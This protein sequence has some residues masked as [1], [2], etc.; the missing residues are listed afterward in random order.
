MLPPEIACDIVHAAVANAELRELCNVLEKQVSVLIALY[1]GY[2]ELLM[3]RVLMARFATRPPRDVDQAFEEAISAAWETNLPAA[4]AGKL[5]LE[6]CVD[7][8]FPLLCIEAMRIMKRDY[9]KAHGT[10]TLRY[11]VCNN[12]TEFVRHLLCCW[13]CDYN[14][15]S[16]VLDYPSISISKNGDT[17]SK[18]KR[19]CIQLLVGHL[20]KD[21]NIVGISDYYGRYA[22]K[23]WKEKHGDTL[24][25]ELAF[26][27]QASKVNT[28][29][30]LHGVSI[31][32][33]N[34]MFFH[35]LPRISNRSFYTMLSANRVAVICLDRPLW[36]MAHPESYP[37]VQCILANYEPVA[38]ED[39][40]YDLMSQFYQG[41][42][43]RAAFHTDKQIIRWNQ[44]FEVTR[45]V[46]RQRIISG[47][48]PK[49]ICG[50]KKFFM[51]AKPMEARPTRKRNR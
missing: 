45:S 15:I 9:G 46:V 25:S 7:R 2:C 18:R 14:R 49:P 12:R 35:S 39:M 33:F 34:N 16:T 11:A 44:E 24:E 1:P 22:R 48:F 10:H 5:F 23:R 36:M 20:Q 40:M 32:Q 31:Q 47:A 17:C 13:P 27:K 38:L 41:R 26:N 21:A 19:E 29:A 6:K 8:D 50:S 43:D 4:W 3:K 28:C 42:E 30:D 51:S 37:Y